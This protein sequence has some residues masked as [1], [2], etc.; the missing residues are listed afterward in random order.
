MVVGLVIPPQRGGCNPEPQTHMA[1]PEGPAPDELVLPRRHQLVDQRRSVTRGQ[2]RCSLRVERE[3]HEPQRVPA[4]AL[5]VGL[6]GVPKEGACRILATEVRL[7]QGSRC[8]PHRH[9]RVDLGGLSAQ[10]D[11]LLVTASL[12]GPHERTVLAEDL[13]RVGL[14]RQLADVERMPGESFPGYEIPL[15]HRPRRNPDLHDPVQRR[16]SESGGELLLTVLN[17]LCSREIACLEAAVQEEEVGPKLECAIL[18]RLR[19]GEQ[20]A[21]QIRSHGDHVRAPQAVGRVLQHACPDSRITD[22]TRERYR[23]LGERLPPDAVVLEE[24]LLRLQCQE[25]GT[26]ARIGAVV[27][28]ERALDR[29]NSLVV[30][31]ADETREAAGIGERCGSGQVRV[32]KR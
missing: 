3:R 15:E 32:A 22:V 2:S 27:Q 1:V 14:A 21:R 5:Q 10:R 12:I 28:L 8:R 16:L 20:I 19:A 7:V 11:Q 9:P 30:E 6:D 25:L 4:H 26:P 18:R 17:D 31:V 23:L 13:P 24:Q 29:I